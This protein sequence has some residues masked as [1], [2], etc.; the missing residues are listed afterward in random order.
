M[1]ADGFSGN[2]NTSVGVSAVK[3][4]I[5]PWTYTD[6]NY[7]LTLSDI[8]S[9]LTAFFSVRVCGCATLIRGPQPG[10]GRED[11]GM[12]W[13][14]L[15]ETAGGRKVEKERMQRG[16][17]G[18][19]GEKGEWRRKKLSGEMREEKSAGRQRQTEGGTRGVEE[20][21]LWSGSDFRCT[22]WKNKKKTR[23]INKNID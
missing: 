13:T 21:S 10:T 7:I 4:R 12:S 3:G 18:A 5:K 23:Q 15:E 8:S 17:R 1:V 20:L 14:R 2:V 22:H 16:R 6:T 9:P 11:H 19:R